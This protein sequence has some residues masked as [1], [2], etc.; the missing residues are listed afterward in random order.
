[1]P[2]YEY[3]CETCGETFEKIRRM[4]D[5]DNPLQCPRCESEQVERLLSAFA[6]ASCGSGARSRFR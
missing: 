6:T 3:R 1:M 5:A 4:Q 2:I